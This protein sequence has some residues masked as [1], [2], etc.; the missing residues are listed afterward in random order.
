VSAINTLEVK[1]EMDVKERLEKI[2]SRGY[3]R[4]NIRPIDFEE[5]KIESL[6]RCWKIIEDCCVR[7]RGWD[8]PVLNKEEIRYGNDWVQSGHNWSGLSELWRFYQSGQFIHY[9]SCIEDYR[10]IPNY[11]PTL[12]RVDRGLSVTSTLYKVTEIYEFATRLAEKNVL[13]NQAKISIKLV[14]M[15]DRTLFEWDGSMIPVYKS[16]SEEIVTDE[17]VSTMELLGSSRDKAIDKTRKILSEFSYEISQ[18]VLVPTQQRLIEK[19][20]G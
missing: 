17:V 1:E 20:L 11:F 13:Q 12:K 5:R 4:V 18:T 16:E 9:F 15:K 3:W 8:Y 14:K 19:R 10:E 6:E 2:K 7:F